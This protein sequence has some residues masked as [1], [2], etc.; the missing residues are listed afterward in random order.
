[1]DLM[2]YSEAAEKLGVS[3]STV[4]KWVKQGKLKEDIEPLGKIKFVSRE[5]VNALLANDKFQFVLRLSQKGREKTNGESAQLKEIAQLKE[6]LLS[7]KDEILQKA[8]IL[9]DEILNRV[10]GIEDKVN[11]VAAMLHNGAIKKET[12]KQESHDSLQIKKLGKGKK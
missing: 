10:R 9:S 8:I 11:N 12:S 2:T 7:I 6:T 3:R 4:G 5:S 1:M